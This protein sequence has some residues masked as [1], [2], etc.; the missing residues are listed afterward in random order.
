MGGSR[1]GQIHIFSDSGCRGVTDRDGLQKLFPNP[2]TLKVSKSLMGKCCQL[3]N[4]GESHSV[5]AATEDYS[6]MHHIT[7]PPSTS[8]QD[9][10]C[11]GTGT[12]SQPN[13]NPT[14]NVPPTTSPIIADNQL[15]PRS[16]E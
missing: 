8:T 4:P 7:P 1:L 9:S 13:P 16:P 14:P 15:H 2:Q 6:H 10:P 5:T 12:A 3:M 11:T